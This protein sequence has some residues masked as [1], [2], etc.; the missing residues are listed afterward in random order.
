MLREP[1]TDA[2][3]P[4]DDDPVGVVEQG[5]KRVLHRLTIRYTTDRVRKGELNKRSADV[6]RGHL[7]SFAA[8]TTAPPD[9]ITRRH[10]EQWLAVEGLSPAYRRTRLSS[11]R[12]FCRWC[13][14]NGH[15]HRDPTLGC[16]TPKVPRGIPRALPAEAAHQLVDVARRADTRTRLILTLML[17]QGMR[18]GEVAAALYDDIDWR[19]QTIAVRGKGYRG[20]TSRILPVTAITLRILGLYLTEHPVNCGPLIRSHRNPNR[21]LTPAHISELVAR[22]FLESGVKTRAGD[23]RSAHALR[24]TMATDMLDGGAD[25]RQVQAALGHSTIKTTE[26]YVQA[27]GVDLRAA[28]EGRSYGT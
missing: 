27:A 19:R 14:L 17:Q 28:M 11:L 20:E 25:L 12:G 3:T 24:H 1:L 10:V 5:D 26:I 23:G 16:A 6:V 18:R 13:I 22:V 7:Y 4:K 8:T 9:R 15:M 2:D 21:G